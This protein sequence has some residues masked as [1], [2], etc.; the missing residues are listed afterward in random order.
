MIDY[1]LLISYYPESTS[2]NAVLSTIVPDM[3]IL[4]WFTSGNLSSMNSHTDE[5]INMTEQ[6]LRTGQDY[7][8]FTDDLFKVQI[9]KEETH[10]TELRS[11]EEETLTIP[12]E[13]FSQYLHSFKQH[14]DN[15]KACIQGG[16][17]FH[18]IGLQKEV[19][20]TSSVYLDPKTQKSGALNELSELHSERYD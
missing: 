15:F 8:T 4:Q 18:G 13:D 16:K 3:E 1:L 2:K 19:T 17:D 7:S 10:I 14:L 12:T 5:W 6:V 11:S 9:G 20:E